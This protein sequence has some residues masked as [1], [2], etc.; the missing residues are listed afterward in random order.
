MVMSFCSRGP[1]VHNLNKR[2]GNRVVAA[3]M[4]QPGGFRPEIPDLFYQN[5]IKGRGPP[6]CEKRPDVTM[7]MVRDFL[8]TMYTNR[9]DSVFTPSLESLPSIPRSLLVAPDHLPA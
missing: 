2:A 3:A 7:D 8:T 5:N 1:V 6:L 4:M 9:A